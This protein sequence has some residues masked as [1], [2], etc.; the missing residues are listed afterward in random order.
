[1]EEAFGISPYCGG[2]DFT[3]NLI[4]TNLGDN[5]LTFVK[6]AGS[7]PQKTIYLFLIDQFMKGFSQFTTP[8]SGVSVLLMK[9]TIFASI[10][11]I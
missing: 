9:F 11:G 5:P 4:S 2:H 10:V 8:S 6:E 1:M 3:A 7:S